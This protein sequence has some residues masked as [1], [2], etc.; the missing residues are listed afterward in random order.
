METTKVVTTRLYG[1]TSKSRTGEWRTRYNAEYLFQ[2]PCIITRE[3]AKRI[4]MLAGH[5]RRIDGAMIKKQRT[6]RT[7][8]AKYL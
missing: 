1:L 7:R 4:I 8:Q 5:T 6:Q 3:I 2:K